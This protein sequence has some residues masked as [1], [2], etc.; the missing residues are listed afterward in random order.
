MAFMNLREATA[1]DASALVGL[2]LLMLTSMG[3]TLVDGWAE[4][5]LA[6]LGRRLPLDGFRCVVVEHQGVVVS[7]AM[8]ELS[9]GQPGPGVAP[10]TALVSN[11]VTLLEARGRGYATQCMDDLLAWAKGRGATLAKLNATEAG[12]PM[13]DKVGFALAGCPEM[14]LPL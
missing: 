2:R 3:L 14:R 10:V 4:A 13:Y 6:W 9:E 7:C 8:A 1:D 5:W 11:V 12:R